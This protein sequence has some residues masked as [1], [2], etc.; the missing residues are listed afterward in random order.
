MYC[1]LMAWW[2]I[3]TSWLQCH[4][5]LYRQSQARYPKRSSTSFLS[6][7]KIILTMRF[8][9]A[10]PVQTTI[11]LSCDGDCIRRFNKKGNQS[12][13]TSESWSTTM[14]SLVSSRSATIFIWNRE[15]D[16]KSHRKYDF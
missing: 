8:L 4:H 5:L 6:P 15:C 13:K 3:V 11:R 9:I 12:S 2:I 1:H 14:L 16:Q 7:K 10:F